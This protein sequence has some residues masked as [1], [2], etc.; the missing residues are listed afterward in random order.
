MMSLKSCLSRSESSGLFKQ[1]RTVIM[2][3]DT[4]ELQFGEE[5]PTPIILDTQQKDVNYRDIANCS[6]PVF[7]NPTDTPDVVCYGIAYP[8]PNT[9]H[10]SRQT[11]NLWHFVTYKKNVQNGQWRNQQWQPIART[12]GEYTTMTVWPTRMIVKSI[13]LSTPEQAVSEEILVCEVYPLS[14]L[15]TTHAS[16]DNRE[17]WVEATLPSSWAAWRSDILTEEW[18]EAAG[19]EQMLSQLNAR[20]GDV[21]FSNVQDLLG[22]ASNSSPNTILSHSAV[23]S[24]TPF[25]DFSPWKPISQNSYNFSYRLCA[26]EGLW[27]FH[28]DIPIDITLETVFKLMVQ[29]WLKCSIDTVDS[30]ASVG[31]GRMLATA[32]RFTRGLPMAMKKVLL[33]DVLKDYLWKH[34]EDAAAQKD[35]PICQEKYQSFTCVTITPCQHMFHK[36]CL[37]QWTM[38]ESTCPMCRR[39]CAVMRFLQCLEELQHLTGGV[40]EWHSHVLSA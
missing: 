9:G 3:N 11:Y 37:D 23:Q 1:S 38:E 20:L 8:Q 33:R 4:F 6:V 25:P 2:S 18:V 15:R 12:E 27:E 39:D 28:G 31:S 35:C 22:E 40:E 30:S 13:G 34:I 5:G 36:A 16:V 26:N 7:F 21:S 19:G 32:V 10:C 17:P 24:W 14:N 29:E